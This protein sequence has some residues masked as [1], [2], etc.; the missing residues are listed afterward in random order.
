ML[1]R[2]W[3]DKDPVAA[4]QFFAY[5]SRSGSRRFPG[6]HR[7]EL[8]QVSAAVREPAIQLLPEPKRGFQ[9]D[10]I[11]DLSQLTQLSP[12]PSCTALKAAAPRLNR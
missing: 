10:E 3:C 4:G 7:C 5:R 12:K 6:S 9:V 1:G 11:S 8:A 2:G